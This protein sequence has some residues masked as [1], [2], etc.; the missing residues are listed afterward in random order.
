LHIGIESTHS[1]RATVIEKSLFG[2]T[3]VPVLLT[4]VSNFGLGTLL[5]YKV[6][7]CG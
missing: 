3:K 5:P 1:A 7:W 4:L 2:D 6:C